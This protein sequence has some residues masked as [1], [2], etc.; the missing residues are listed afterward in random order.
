M[1]VTPWLLGAA[2]RARAGEPAWPAEL[3]L[4]AFWIAAYLT[5]QAG[6]AW[7]KAA[8]A[9][10]H[11]YVSPVLTYGAVAGA[12]GVLALWLLGPA[13][14]WWTPLFLPLLSVALWFAWRRKERAL[15]GGVVTV[16]AAALLGLVARHPA[17]ALPDAVTALAVGASFVYFTG[18]VLYVKTM[19]RERNKPVW[20]GV[21]I[22]YH[23]VAAMACLIGWALGGPVLLPWL[24]LFFA[25]CT[26]RAAWLPMLARRR[27]V[28]PKT[29]GFLEI[30]VTVA[31]V[32]ACLLP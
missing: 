27:P 28:A 11:S 6:S 9:K 13:A 21:S 18:T 4:L 19:I 15:L 7:L 25:A 29:V 1:L 30:G 3:A 16:A 14:L 20:L 23:A 5:F 31:L 24:A 8:P 17:P 26:A 2:L 10:R 12:L 22:G 32:A